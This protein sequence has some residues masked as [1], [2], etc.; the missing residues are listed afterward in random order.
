MRFSRFDK[1]GYDTVG[2]EQ[3]Y[4]E[5]AAT[6]EDTVPDLLDIRL[7]EQVDYINWPDIGRAIDLACGTGRIGAWLKSAG[8]SSV[9]GADAAAGMLEKAR[10]RGVYDRIEQCDLA[11]TPFDAAAYDVSMA[12]LVDEH[13]PSLDGLYTEVA[14]LTAEGG[15]FVI[16]GY[17]PHFMMLTGMP[18]HFARPDGQNVAIETYVHLFAEHFRAGRDAGWSLHDLRE[19][20]IDE[21]WLSVKPKWGGYTGHPVSFLMAWRR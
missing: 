14:R 1:R 6:Y 4:D 19:S 21:S 18:T 3:G 11:S 13:L 9:D 5:W 8:V 16:V 15:W 10:S 12:V 17:H 2:P 7:L 20:C